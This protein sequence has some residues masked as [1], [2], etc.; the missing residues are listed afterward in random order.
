M[1]LEKKLISAVLFLSACSCAQPATKELVHSYISE[2]SIS[3]TG[4]YGNFAFDGFL[5]ISPKT[6]RLVLTEG[7]TSKDYPRLSCNGENR[8]SLD[9]R[10]F[11]IPLTCSEGR[12]GTAYLIGDSIEGQSGAGRYILSDGSSGLLVYGAAIYQ[13]NALSK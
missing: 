4:N 13:G 11:S 8:R 7:S 12:E 2:K 1:N 5:E 3:P 9:D 6:A 10:H